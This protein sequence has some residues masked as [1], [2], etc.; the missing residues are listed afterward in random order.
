MLKLD[1]HQHFWKY[2]PKKQPWI[3]QDM[4]T[5]QHDFMPE[6]LQPL[7]NKSGV[8]GCIAV[9][10]DENETENDFLLSLAKENELIKG[11]IGW[12]DFLADDIYDKV[13][14]YNDM[15]LMKGFRYMLQGKKQRDL[16]LSN[17]FIRGV[18]AMNN[19]DLVYELLVLPDQLNYVDQFV[20]HFPEQLFVL[21]HL[22]KP[23]IKT[24]EIAQWTSAISSLAKHEN[25]YCKVSGMV[26]EAD[27]T[28]WSYND[29]AP[30]MDVVFSSFGIDR[31][32]FGSDWPVCNLA[33]DYQK[34]MAVPAQW[35]S[36]LSANEQEKFW[37]G[38][39]IKCYQL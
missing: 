29:L 11:V 22:A 9:Q 2:H 35:V 10:V 8:S 24:G 7:L 32:M 20:K 15:K 31:V 25:I 23:L 19:Y 13:A 39:A 1:T 6:D 12:V 14:Y 26:T 21:N 38:N 4:A 27:W 36:N 28:N 3:S 5:I 37:S 30:Y 33:G 16:I 18:F 17:E 34:T